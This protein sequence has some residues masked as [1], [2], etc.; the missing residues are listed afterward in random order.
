LTEPLPRPGRA[1]R[2]PL[3]A[4]FSFGT[5]T[6]AF[7]IEGAAAVGGRT[8][9]IWDVFAAAPGRITD[10]SSGVD[11]IDH[12]HRWEQDLRLL[13]ELGATAYRF[14]LSWSRIQPGGSGPASAAG[15]GFYDRLIDRLLEFGI[16]P[17][18][19]LYHWDMP[20]EVMGLGGWLS[21][22]TAAAFGD[23][24]ELAA[25]AF[26]DRVTAWTTVNEPLVELA[27]GYAI[28]IDAPG[29]ALLGGAFQAAHHQ[30]LAHARAV[31]VL[32]S[33]VSGSVGIINHH[34]CVDPAARRGA[35]I[36]AARF[37]DAYHNRQFAD[38]LLLGEYPKAILDMPGAATEV[39]ADGDLALISAPLDFYGV[40]YAHP[41]VVAA[42]PENRSI[43]FSLEVPGDR[44]LTAGGWPDHPESLT[45][46][47]GDLTARYPT[48]P[49]V[50]VTG[51][52]G[53][54][55]DPHSAGARQPDLHRIAY[56]DGHL[57]AI[58]AAIQDGCDV[59]GYFHW[60]LLDSWE[61][62][63]GFTRRF[64]LVRVDPETLEREP[65]ASYAHFR[66]LIRRG[67][68]AGP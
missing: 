40:S 15:L 8:P 3:P 10:G 47:L 36:A 6:S 38:P 21:R 43:P 48:L 53:A 61:W 68:P 66:T 45:R 42:A 29:L 23:Y 51:I 17:F 64:G 11:A 1:H 19:G 57:A 35:D 12:Y 5:A 39:I 14:S 28:G 13:A 67:R 58:A 44:R 60:A 65:R 30:L 59:R 18:V 54:F 9:S 31:Q 16:A 25:V 26:G 55:D 20:L 24:T 56:L 41:T 4:G 22:D 50:Y 63:E 7:Q 62:A 52:G 32:R 33:T 46:V 27:Y 34:T 49:P 37:Y 2:L